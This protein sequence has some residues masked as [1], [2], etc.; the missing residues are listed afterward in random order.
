[1]EALGLELGDGVEGGRCLFPVPASEEGF[2][3]QVVNLLELFSILREGDRAIEGG[4]GLLGVV[5]LQI[6]RTHQQ[7]E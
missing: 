3:A 7:A 5:P 2:S 1:M 4:D 6:E